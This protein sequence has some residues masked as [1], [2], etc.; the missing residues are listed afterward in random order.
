MIADHGWQAMK[1]FDAQLSTFSTHLTAICKYFSHR[2]A[3]E[4]LLDMQVVC[5][6]RTYMP[7]LSK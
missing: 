6:T 4:L 2:K 1:S 7:D 5:G 3:W